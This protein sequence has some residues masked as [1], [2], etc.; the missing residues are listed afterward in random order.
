MNVLLTG[1]GTGGHVYPALA[2][3][4]ALRVEPQ[5]QP[6]SLLFVGTRDRLEAKIV[7]K[8]GIPLAYAAAAPLQRRLSFSLLRTLAMNALGVVQAF[9]ILHR[10]RPDCVV[11]T[12]GY[13]T[14]PSRCVSCARWV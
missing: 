6:L 13:V 12:G 2:I 11:A 3:A 4:E 8:A 9:G 14:F 5:A 7:P 10:F 1:G